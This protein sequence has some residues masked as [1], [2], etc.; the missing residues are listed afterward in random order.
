MNFHFRGALPLYAK[1]IHPRV[2]VG[3][4]DIATLRKR[5]RSGYGKKIMDGM[6]RRIRPIVSHVLAAPDHQ[7]VLKAPLVDGHF[8]TTNTYALEDIAMVGLIDNDKRAV[9]T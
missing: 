7:R 2:L 8:G 3:P 9:E 4:D 1:R 5:I 6:R